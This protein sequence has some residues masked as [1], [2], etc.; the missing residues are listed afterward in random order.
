MLLAFLLSIFQFLIFVHK[1]TDNWLMLLESSKEKEI[2]S[3]P[4]F[5]ILYRSRK[6]KYREICL[7]FLRW[8][9]EYTHILVVIT[10][11]TILVPHL[12]S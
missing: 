12:E 8:C 4:A 1:Y 6:K 7:F 9:L 3:D 11:I 10:A 2:Y 5:F